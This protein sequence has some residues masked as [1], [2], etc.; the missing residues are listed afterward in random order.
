MIHQIA[1]IHTLKKKPS[2]E[3]KG[4]LYFLYEIIK[5][6]EALTA[7]TLRGCGLLRLCRR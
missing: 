2:S 3:E 6:H 1:A 5:L 4:S 7:R